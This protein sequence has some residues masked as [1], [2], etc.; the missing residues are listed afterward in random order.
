MQYLRLSVLCALTVITTPL[1]STATPFPPNWNH[2]H[3]KHRWNAIPGKWESIGQPPVGTTIDL[4]IALRPHREHALADA[5]HEVSNPKHPK[6]ALCFILPPT[7]VTLLRSRYGAY[8]SKEQVAKLV[9]PHPY[10]LKLVETWLR[11]HGV[12]PSNVSTSHG[13]NW[14]TVTGVPVSTAN[15]LLGASYQL[16]RYAGTNETILRTVG[17]ALPVALHVHVQTVAPT[18]Y[19]GSPLTPRERP[20]GHRGRAVAALSTRGGL[21]TPSFLRRLYNSATYQPVA[22]HQNTIGVTGFQGQYVGDEDLEKFMRL[23]R[24]DARN[25]TFLVIDINDSGYDPKM[26]GSE[27][28]LDMQ[29]TQGIAWPTPHV[30]YSIGGLAEEFIPDSFTPVNTN[31][32]Y[33]RWLDTMI[34]QEDIPQ[35]ISTSY[36]GNEQTFPPDYAKSVC[37]LFGQLGARGVSMLFASGDSGVGGGDCKKNDGSG[38]VEFQPL[39]PATCTCGCEFSPLT[40]STQAQIP[41]AHHPATH[42]AGP[43]VTSVGGTMGRPEVAAPFSTG[44]F[45]NVFKRPGYQ[46]D[47]VLGFF[48]Q[49]GSQHSGLYNASSRGSPDVSAQA[50]RFAIVL[51]DGVARTSGTSCSAPVVA[52]IVSLLNDYQLSMN[53]PVL[54]FLNP[55]L[56]G[57]ASQGFNDITSGSNPGCGTDGF[58]AVPGWDPVTGLGTPDFQRLLERLPIPIPTP[59]PTN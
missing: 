52:G 22:T 46:T 33:L 4:S 47:A 24:S 19:F 35:T 43:W 48:Q 26:P 23:F 21:V 16:Y 40:S 14:L 18:T 39:F 34:R 15:E 49:L 5:I 12:S 1:D 38:V 55:W 7:H 6:H 58:S 44:G 10:T 32:P 20:R 50:V 9:A 13:G 11:H 54:G 45:S 8:L 51:N 27:A 36:G 17:Y 25:P 3:T 57:T 30:F 59:I 2:M 29:Y 41:V 37:E 42:F 28:N 53:R 56:Y 31:E